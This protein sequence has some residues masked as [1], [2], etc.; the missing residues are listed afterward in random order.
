[1]KTDVSRFRDLTTPPD[2]LD[3]YTLLT[4]LEETDTNR[5]HF[6]CNGVCY[7]TA[8]YSKVNMARWGKLENS[9][10]PSH[11]PLFPRRVLKKAPY[12]GV[13]G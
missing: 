12:L 9:Q 13:L 1:M 8:T 10:L 11:C 3:F 2:V 5:P 4:T 6:F 7:I